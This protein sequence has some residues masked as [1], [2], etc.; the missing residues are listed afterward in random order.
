MKKTFAILIVIFSSLIIACGGS[1]GGSN[2]GGDGGGTAPP[3]DIQY[4]GLTTPAVI[5]NSNATAISEGAFSGGTAA[6]AFALSATSE[7]N[8]SAASAA[9]AGS[10]SLYGLSRVFSESASKISVNTKAP[11]ASERFAPLATTTE[12]GTING[13]CGGSATYSFKVDDQTG[14]FSGTFVFSNYCDAGTTINGSTTVNGTMDLVDE[15]IVTINY[16]FNGMQSSD[17]VLKGTV[18]IDDSGYPPNSSTTFNLLVQNTANSKVYKYDNYV[19]SGTEVDASISFDMTGTYY[20]PDYGYVAVT[21]PVDFIVGID[22]DWPS[23]GEMLCVGA[24]ASRTKLTALNITTYNVSVDSNGDGIYE[25]V[26][27]PFNWSDL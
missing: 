13:D 16:T 3:A 24:N 8:P 2:G 15:V 4:T 25:T 21:T 12:S 10:Q 14:A 18:G 23:S 1:G 20:D 26:L 19:L 9:Y 7:E 27:G 11:N 22:D 6:S 17:V 5:T